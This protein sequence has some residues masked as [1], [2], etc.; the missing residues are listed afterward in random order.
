MSTENFTKFPNHIIETVMPELSANGWKV[1]CFIW[2]K[3]SGWKKTEDYISISQIMDGTGIKSNNTTIAAIKEVSKFIKVEGGRGRSNLHKFSIEKY[4]KS[5]PLEEIKD[6]EIAPLL[7]KDAEIEA[8]PAIK[9]AVFDVKDAEIA[10]TKDTITKEIN[11][12]TEAPEEGYQNLVSTEQA[13][14]TKPKTPRQPK[15]TNGN[16]NSNIYPLAKEIM[17]LMVVDEKIIAN[18]IKSGIYKVAKKFIGLGITATDISD[19]GKWWYVNDWRGQRKQPPTLA[20]ISS[21]WG[22]FK[23]ASN[24]GGHKTIV[25]ADGGMYL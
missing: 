17:S 11:T 10:H 13:Q 21:E 2:R 25:T 19:F 23:S 9:D 24:G 6:A 1:F 20:Q 12:T 3:T 4:V 5:A 14:K 7:E 18:G 22:K 16:G 15:P 8:L